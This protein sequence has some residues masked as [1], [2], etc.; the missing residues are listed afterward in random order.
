MNRGEFP[1]L[2]FLAFSET[3]GERFAPLKA[4]EAHCRAAIS[5]PSAHHDRTCLVA[6]G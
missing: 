2:K 4:V 3:L 1:V 6:G 5:P